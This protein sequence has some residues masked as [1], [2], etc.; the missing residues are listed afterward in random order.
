MNSSSLNTSFKINVPVEIYFGSGEIKHLGKV[1]A[2]LGKKAVLITTPELQKSGL[3]KEALKYLQ[4]YRV[5]IT[6]FDDLQSEPDCT[7]IENHARQIKGSSPDVIVAFGGGSAMD[8]AKA[9]AIAVTHPRPIWDY[10]NLSNRPPL[11]IQEDEVLPVVAVPTTAGTGSEVTPYAVLINH[12]TTQK[13]TI[14]S[15]AIFPKF[16]IIDPQLM[17]TLPPNLTAACGFDAFAHALESYINVKFASAFSNLMAESAMWIIF[18]NLPQ[19]I[20]D[21]HNVNLRSQMALGSMLAGMAIAHAG[22]TVAHALAQP[23][24][25]RIK[26]PHS[27]T[28]AIFTPAVLKYTWQADITRFAKIYDVL[29]PTQEEHFS[30]EKKADLAV[31]IINS[32]IKKIGLNHCISEFHTN[33]KLI[34][35]LLEDVMNYM[36]RPLQQHP[37]LFTIEEIRQIICKSF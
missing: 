8:A 30:I 18:R 15:P 9:L 4:A 20:E 7:W 11:A 14:K 22:T 37:K 32:F 2:A 31:K 6:L 13:G 36:S 3:V 27:L 24:G 26:L 17:S 5:H 35:D 10:V 29:H 21:R 16:A 23:L 19:V 33:R 25:V 34:D 12:E 28:V 1:T